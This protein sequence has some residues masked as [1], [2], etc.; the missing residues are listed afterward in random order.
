MFGIAANWPCCFVNCLWKN[1]STGIF[2]NRFDQEW[3]ENLANAACCRSARK[4]RCNKNCSGT[5][6][7]LA[8]EGS[9]KRL[10]EAKSVRKIDMTAELYIE[11]GDSSRA[12]TLKHYQQITF[13]RAPIADAV[14]SS[15]SFLSGTHFEIQFVPGAAILR[16]LKSSNG[17]FLNGEKVQWRT[18]YDGDQ[19]KAG[20]STFKIQIRSPTEEIAAPTIE[21]P[22]E[23]GC[24]STLIESR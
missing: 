6:R 18:I 14:I 13:G 24:S 9:V 5:Y 21:K 12:W 4:I 1:Q 16:D 19:I 20:N 7:F 10:L 11:N 3:R 23:F 2:N 17:T 8:V 15:D 22:I